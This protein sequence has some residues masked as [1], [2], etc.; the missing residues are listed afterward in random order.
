[1]VDIDEL[2]NLGDEEL[3]E[4]V[5]KGENL[6]IPNSRASTAKRI[7][8]SRRAKALV[9]IPKLDFPVIKFDIPV[10]MTSIASANASLSAIA[11]INKDLASIGSIFSQLG[12]VQTQQMKDLAESIS[13]AKQFTGLA[14]GLGV[15]HTKYIKDLADS[16]GS[17]QKIAGTALWQDI[18]NKTVDS[19]IL[20]A[21]NSIQKLDAEIIDRKPQDLLSLK[22]AEEVSDANE[23]QTDSII[24][25]PAYT[26]IFNLEVFLRG[27]IN[28][29]IIT[30]NQ[31]QLASK[32]PQPTLD[33]WTERKESEEDNLYAD[34][35]PYELI[36]YSDF[37][38][39][40]EIL[41]KSTTAP[42]IKDVLNQENLKVIAARLIELDPIRKKIAHSR[43]LTKNELNRLK[44]HSD[45]IKKILKNSS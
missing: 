20:T 33:K 4:I 38:D 34:H 30:P 19:P 15:A 2:N 3:D 8:E 40:K 16:F 31:H 36:E 22:L 25:S 39:L 29:Y 35:L 10:S 23:Q 45:T 24:N 14:E 17:I 1:M 9:Q 12:T 21:V 26:Y 32:I 13:T 42:L 5:I 7:L 41:E 27:F 44:D 37:T 11:N 28:K 18:A 6:H 43:A